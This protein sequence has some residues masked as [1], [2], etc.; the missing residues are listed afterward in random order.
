MTQTIAARKIKLHDL[1]TRFGLQQVQGD[2]FFLEWTE[3]L[4][5]V[6]EAERFALD[7]DKAQLSLSVGVSGDGK[8]CKNGS[9]ITP[10]GHSRIL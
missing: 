6:S 3:D 9:A 1:K 7:S 5:E 2:S 10:T 8:H 4:P